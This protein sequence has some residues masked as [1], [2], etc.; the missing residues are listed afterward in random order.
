VIAAGDEAR[1]GLRLVAD[2]LDLRIKLADQ[3]LEHATSD[4]LRSITR[5]RQVGLEDALR[6]VRDAIAESWQAVPR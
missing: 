4:H 3:A 6:I 5:A 1:A 2:R